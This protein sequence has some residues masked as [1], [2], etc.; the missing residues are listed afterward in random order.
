MADLPIR[1]EVI[2]PN[3]LVRIGL[4]GLIAEL[5]GRAVVTEP[6]STR[7]H[8]DV[9]IYDIGGV[10]EP[11]ACA[12]LQHLIDTG[13]PVVGLLYDIAK[14]TEP[15]AAR[16]IHVITLSVTAEQLLEVLAR[17]VP[18]RQAVHG[19]TL[20]L[21]ANLTEREFRVIALIGEGLSNGQI[22]AELFVSQNTVKTYIRMA[23]RKMGV[24]NRTAAILWALEHGLASGPDETEHAD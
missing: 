24:P 17:A 14:G 19:D 2:S 6:A 9:V 10:E 20:K 15:A 13:S 18:A 7:G 8:H 16:V 21:P 22:A 1:V 23:Y 4:V 12:E 11:I 3:P 5:R